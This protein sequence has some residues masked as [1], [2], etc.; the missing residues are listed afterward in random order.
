[1]TR[2][3]TVDQLDA[4]PIG[5]IVHWPDTSRAA[6]V[7]LDADTW[8]ITGFEN[9][10]ETYRLLG[11]NPPALLFVPGRDLVQEAKANAWDEGFRAGLVDNPY[12]DE[13]P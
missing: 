4:L 10:Y 13:A 7:K 6:A 9:G 3:E 5:S 1:M 11:G 2:I 8:T 12:R